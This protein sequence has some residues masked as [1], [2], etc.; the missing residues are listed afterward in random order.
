ML[1]GERQSAF[2][3][4]SLVVGQFQRVDDQLLSVV[5][6]TR[7]VIGPLEE[8]EE[9]WSGQRGGEKKPSFRYDSTEKR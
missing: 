3:S 2:D 7:H 4:V 5:G 6:R 1:S 8:E 9:G